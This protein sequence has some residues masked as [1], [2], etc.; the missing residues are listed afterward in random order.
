MLAPAHHRPLGTV[1]A[2]RAP[3]PIAPPASVLRSG[4]PSEKSCLAYDRHGRRARGLNHRQGC[5]KWAPRMC[6]R[7]NCHTDDIAA[8]YWPATFAKHRPTVFTRRKTMFHS[9]FQ[10]AMC[11]LA[12]AGAVGCG[13]FPVHAD[14]GDD[15]HRV[16]TVFV[17]AMENHNWTQPSTQTSPQQIFQNP[18]APFINSLVNGTSGISNQVSYANAYINAGPGIH[19]SEPNYIWAEAGTNFGVTNDDDPY[20]ADCTPDTVQTTNQHLSAFLTIGRKSWK[21]YQEDTD[22]DATNTPLPTSSWTVPLFSHSGVFTAPGVNAYNYSNQ[23]N[24]ATK[25]NPMPFF[26]DTNGSQSATLLPRTESRK[27]W[28]DL[29]AIFHFRGKHGEKLCRKHT[30]CSEP[31]RFLKEKNFH[32]AHR[33]ASLC[34][35]LRLPGE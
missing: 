4:T 26:T 29:M 16:K 17:I 27:S 19:P 2:L 23:Y 3:R 6:S 14:G 15:D 9:K 12:L 28:N 31:L 8:K 25:H 22:V 10:R 32:F 33:N 20:H 5:C 11:G 1:P 21:S 30:S 13:C 34:R 24:Y 35:T 18:A 7:L